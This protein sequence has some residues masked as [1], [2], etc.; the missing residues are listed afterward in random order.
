MTDTQEPTV[1]RFP[2]GDVRESPHSISVSVT[3]KGTVTA[4]VKFYFSDDS[5]TAIEDVVAGAEHALGLIEERFRGSFA[6]AKDLEGR[7]VTRPDLK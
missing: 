6:L 1:A 5:A 4:D 3:S 7:L 2:N